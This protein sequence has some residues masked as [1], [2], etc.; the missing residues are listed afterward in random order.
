MDMVEDVTKSPSRLT[1]K[2]KI[3]GAGVITK[4]MQ[5]ES[6]AGVTTAQRGH[7]EKGAQPSSRTHQRTGLVTETDVPRRAL[8]DDHR[9]EKYIFH[10]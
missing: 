3:H 2:G 5:D 9:E 1:Q 4:R 6:T 7:N 8:A 10:A